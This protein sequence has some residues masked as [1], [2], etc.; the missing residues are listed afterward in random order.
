MY[1][2]LLILVVILSLALMSVEPALAQEGGP[3]PTPLPNEPVEEGEVASTIVIKGP[4]SKGGIEPLGTLQ[5]PGG[6]SATLSSILSYWV[7]LGTEH[8]KGGGKIA[9]NQGQTA[10]AWTTLAR[11]GVQMQTTS[12][13][14][15]WT[16]IVCTSWTSYYT[17]SHY[18][19]LNYAET[20][21]Y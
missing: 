8:V 20:T 6:Q 21:V 3:P 11:N 7:F 5:G 14:P 18:Y 17:G 1:K 2:T 12:G 9:P 19:W 4:H 16:T 13:S 15:C 10:K